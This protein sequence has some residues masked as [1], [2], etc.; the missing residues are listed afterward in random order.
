[1]T[2]AKTI[3]H[4]VVYS[5]KSQINLVLLKSTINSTEKRESTQKAYTAWGN[6][7]LVF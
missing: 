2:Q 4:V 6:S 1:M 3:K 7:S 5:P